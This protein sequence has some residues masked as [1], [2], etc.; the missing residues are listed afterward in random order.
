EGKPRPASDQYALGVL[1]YEWL[2]GR[3]P[4]Q[5][6]PMEVMMQHMVAQPA[7]LSQQVPMLTPEVEQVVFTAM[8]KDPRQRFGSIQAFATA[9]TRASQLHQSFP[10]P[11]S[12]APPS[13]L[14]LPSV[15]TMPEANA[16][17]FGI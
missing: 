3:R 10:L 8:A 7:S 1:T 4:F 15:E 11:T 16:S 12:S 5:G 2:S 17:A 9:L 14:P 13:P 6:T